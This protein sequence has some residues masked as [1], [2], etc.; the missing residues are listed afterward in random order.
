MPAFY[1]IKK[2]VQYKLHAKDE[3][4]I[5]SPFVFKL[6]TEVISNQNN[7]HAFDELNKIRQQLLNNQQSIEVIDLGAGS[8][9]MSN[10]RTIAGIAKYSVAQ[11]K[12]SELLFRLTNYFQPQTVLELG[13]SL[14]LSALYMAQ[15]APSA[16]IISIEGCPNTHA[17]A[18]K[19]IAGTQVKNIE[20]INQ[21]FDDAF[22][23]TLKNKIFNLVYIDGNHTYQATINYFN[24]LLKSTT[25]NSVLIFDDIYW[26]PQMTQ[27]WEEIKAHPAV[28]LSIDLYKVG[29]IFFRKENKQKE[30]FIL[31]Y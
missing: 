11:K 18:Q 7:Y 26:T 22:K 5:H 10:T 15:A 6:Y 23:T 24:E 12:Y 29:L 3:H 21:S 31:K 1:Q 30:H 2:Y 13:T 25:E 19:L 9:K 27:A 16:N 17:F 4:S 14:G 20:T 28:T 8:K